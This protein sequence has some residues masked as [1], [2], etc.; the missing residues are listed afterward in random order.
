MHGGDHAAAIKAAAKTK[1]PI[2]DEAKK[3]KR[4]RAR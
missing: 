4:A 2:S 3:I 1:L